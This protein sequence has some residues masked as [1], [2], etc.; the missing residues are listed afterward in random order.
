MPNGGAG[1]F[2]C[3]INMGPVLPPQ[4]KGRLPQYS[5]DKLLALQQKC[6]ELEALGVLKKPEDVNITV[7]NLNP[8][9]LVK[10]SNGGFRLVTAFEDVGRYSKPQPSL[11]PDIDSTL[12]TIGKWKYIIVSDLTSSFYQIPLSRGS[13]KICGIVTPYRGIRVYTRCAM[14]M[15]GSETALEEMM[16]RVLGDCLQDGCVAKLADDLYCGGET[17]DEL[18]ENWHR[19]LKC[20]QNSGLRLSA[21]KTIVCPRTATILGWTWSEGRISASQHKIATLASCKLPE[22]VTGLRSFLGAYKILGRVIPDCANLL[23]P[24]E[25][26]ISGLQSKDAVKWTDDLVTH[27]RNAQSRLSA[28][29]AITLPMPSDEL[30]IVTD[31]SVSKHGIGATMYAMRDGKLRLA[32]FFSAKLRKHQVTWLPCE[33][34]ALSIA[35]AIKHYS[36]YI[37][38]SNHQTHVLTDSKPCV[39]AFEKL[40]RGE[41]S[42]S[43]RVT[44]FLSTASR[45]NTTIRHLAGSANVPSD[46]ASRNAVDCHEPRCQICNFIAQTEDAVVRSISVQDVINNKIALPYIT[47]SAW[48][49]I[50]SECPDLRRTHAHLKQGTRPSRKLTNLKDVKRY[51][52]VARIAR[53]GLLVVDRSDPFQPTTELIIVPRS[54]LDGLITALHI[55]LDHPTRHQMQMVLKRHFYA[56]DLPR[57]IE[58]AC[59]SCHTCASLKKFPDKLE[60]QTSDDKVA[61]IGTVFAADVLKRNCQLVCVLRESVTSYTTACVIPN[62]KRETLREALLRLVMELHPLDGPPAVIRVDPAPGFFALRDDAI[63]GKFRI[64]LE[65]GRVKNKNKNPVA[66][67]AI[68]ELEDE[69]LRQEPG[70]GPGTDFTLSVA[71]ARLNSRIRFTGLSARELWTQRSQFTN[72]Q[73]PVSDLHAIDQKYALRDTNHPASAFSKWKSK[74]APIDQSLNVGDLVYLY[75]D[76]DK[77][78]GRSRYFI[79]AIDGEWCFIKKFAGKQLRSNSYKVKLT[80][81]YRVL[82]EI[83]PS[84]IETRHCGEDETDDEISAEPTNTTVL[85]Q[86]HNP[87]DI[88]RTLSQPPVA[89][90]PTMLIGIPDTN[91]PSLPEVHEIPSPPVANTPTRPTRDR[92]P[93]KW[94]QDYVLN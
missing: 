28:N 49:A 33:V 10:K 55:S 54:V 1:K 37:I 73:L 3:H 35:A 85:A 89:N 78:K 50:Q 68:A 77:S 86:Y 59:E 46:F 19:V 71:V 32:G 15:P 16:C 84:R 64:V 30:W 29:K 25:N 75:T 52:S 27:L 60:R 48:F 74:R 6:D 7:E 91:D 31:G 5:R 83:S 42:A 12:R 43:P 53:D 93:P 62:E 34:E 92:R 70:G 18:A 39:Q 79:T 9:F 90:E 94:L 81:C 11:M 4:R 40:R 57:A 67:K 66:E 41:F 56:L 45:Y 87:P 58:N 8:S 76:R 88:P 69:L 13:L 38:Q 24:L 21:S 2:E 20:L 44:S 17:I 80:E 14:G 72:E 26:A 51:L 23:A 63:L 65:F 61:G 36:P 22:T 82:C 47:R